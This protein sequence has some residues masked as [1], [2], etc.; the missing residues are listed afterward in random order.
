MPK[1]KWYFVSEACDGVAF[2]SLH[3]PVDPRYG[4]WVWGQIGDGRVEFIRQ[5]TEYETTKICARFMVWGE[6]VDHKQPWALVV[7]IPGGSSIAATQSGLDHT[8]GVGV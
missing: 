4:H 5:M 1:D 8:G 2:W 3:N 6:K 7:G